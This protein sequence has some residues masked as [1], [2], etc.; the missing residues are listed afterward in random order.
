MNASA[1]ALPRAVEVQSKIRKVRAFSRNA[2]VVCAA[3]FGLSVA[4]SVIVMLVM[5]LM[6][7]LGPAREWRDNGGLDDVMR[8]VLTPLQ[9]NLWALC[10][11]SIVIGIWLNIL[12]QLERLFGNLAAGAIYTPE[13]VRHLRNV[14]FLSLL[15]AALS[16]LIPTTHV[17]VLRLIS[18]TVP[19]DLD[20]IFLSFYEL[21]GTLVTPGLI[22]LVSW[23]MDV[24]LYEKEHADALR[25]EADLVI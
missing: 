21:I 2:R 25:R 4:G 8:A 16:I 17:V 3:L 1:S 22:L 10:I 13:N 14:G 12:R 9:F 11:M 15:W 20:R 18:S 5:T 19:I 24:G 6:M 23:I 7:V